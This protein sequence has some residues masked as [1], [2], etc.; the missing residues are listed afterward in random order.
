MRHLNISKYLSILCITLFTLAACSDS[1][2]DVTNEIAPDIPDLTQGQPEFDFFKGKVNSELAKAAGTN[3][4][5][6]ATLTASVEAIMTSFSTLPVSF[7]AS[8]EGIDASFE[9][10]IWTWN[11]TYGQAGA[12]ITIR[13]TAEIKIA[14]TNWAMYISATNGEESF[15]NYKFMDGFVKNTSN[16]GEWNFY[17]F[18]EESST[19]VMKYTWDIE[20]ET[21]ATFTITFEDTS[22]EGLTYVKATPDNTITLIDANASN[23]VIYWNSETGTGYYQVS[24]VASVCWD[25]SG[26]NIACS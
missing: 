17:S 13:L 20:S 12:S 4:D 11:Y 23:T 10:G 9:D 25:E 22:F 5:F 3:F 26:N 19:E 14:Q 8:A 2:T 21:N 6:A 1:G 18:E 24:D 16:A 15:D 7:T